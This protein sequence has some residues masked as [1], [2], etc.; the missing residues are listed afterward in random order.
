M[1]DLQRIQA[2]V[3]KLKGAQ[4]E[5]MGTAGDIAHESVSLR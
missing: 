2:G 4:N 1:A 5:Q 3:D